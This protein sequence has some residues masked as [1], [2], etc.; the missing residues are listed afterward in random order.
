MH[1][2]GVVCQKQPAFPQLLDQLLERRLTNQIDAAITERRGDLRADRLVSGGAEE[3]PLVRRSPRPSR[4]SAPATIVSP[5]HIP[6]RDKA[7]SVSPRGLA[8]GRGAI[9]ISSTLPPPRL[10]TARCQD[11]APPGAAAAPSARASEPAGSKASADDARRIQP[12]AAHRPARARAPRAKSSEKRFRHQIRLAPNQ[13][14]AHCQRDFRPNE[15]TSSTSGTSR[16]TAAIFSGASTVTCASGRPRLIARTAGMLMTLSPSQL[17]AANENTKWLQTFVPPFPGRKVRVCIA[18][19]QVRPRR[20]PAIMNPE[21][22]FRRAP[23]LLRDHSFIF[24]VSD[25]TLSLGRSKAGLKIIRHL[26]GPSVKREAAMSA[27]PVRLQSS[28]GS[29]EVEASRPK[30]GV[31]RPWSP[32]C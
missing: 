9:A 21:P 20:F 26:P 4:R 31:Q 7:Q 15:I 14:D 8:E 1:R 24:A 29:G 32:A 25:A 10:T 3:H 22:V 27:A 23:D 18:Q 5:A 30:N 6:R 13:I 12:G 2:A 17:L 16:Q 19:E 28:A 11:N